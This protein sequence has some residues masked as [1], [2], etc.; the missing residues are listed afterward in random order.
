[1]REHPGA[2]ILFTYR[3][4]QSS[5]LPAFLIHPNTYSRFILINQHYKQTTRSICYPSLR[6]RS[7]VQN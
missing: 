5:G 2:A 7:L 3:G 6:N 4:T 1:M